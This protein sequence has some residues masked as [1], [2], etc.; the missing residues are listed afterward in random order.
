MDELV[1]V[2]MLVVPVRLSC[3][4]RDLVHLEHGDLRV[5][6]IGGVSGD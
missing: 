2:V 1:N 3:R 6:A 5:Q 4:E